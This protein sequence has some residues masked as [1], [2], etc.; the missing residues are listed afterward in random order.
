M[1][2]TN[3]LN[4]QG[5]SLIEV[6]VAIV[7]LAVGLMSLISMQVTGIKGNAKASNITVA[8]GYGADRLEKLFALD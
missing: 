8:S 1:M 6:L 2:K 3:T 4:Q 5:F 7:I